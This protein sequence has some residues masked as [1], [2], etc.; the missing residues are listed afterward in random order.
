MALLY[1]LSSTGVKPSIISPTTKK[2]ADAA[3]MLDLLKEGMG[4]DPIMDRFL[5]K[6]CTEVASVT[7]ITDINTLACNKGILNEDK[8][9]TDISHEPRY[10]TG[11]I[12]K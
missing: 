8:Y 2:I 6:R 4:R 3:A 9:M 7:G 5:E 1:V 12:R 11:K 10:G